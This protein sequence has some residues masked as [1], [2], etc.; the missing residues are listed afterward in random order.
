VSLNLAEERSI[1]L[2]SE[3]LARGIGIEAGVFDLGDADALLAAPWAGQVTRVLVEVLFEHDD[4]SAVELGTA[5]DGRVASL[6]RPRLWH[7]D[8]RAT[9]AV[10]DAGL[11]DG[12]DVRVG[13]EDT[14]IDRD[15]TPA[16]SNLDQVKRILAGSNGQ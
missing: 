3:L 10:V 8:G 5:I 6:G 15:G 13:L 9:W 4:A 7:G 2:G 12:H 11:A 14:L 16:P 1:E